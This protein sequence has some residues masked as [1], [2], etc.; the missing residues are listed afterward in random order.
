MAINS[1]IIASW[2]VVVE[3]C[4]TGKSNIKSSWLMAMERSIAVKSHITTSWPMGVGKN[5]WQPNLILHDNVMTE[6]CGGK[7]IKIMAII[8]LMES[9]MTD[10]VWQYIPSLHRNMCEMHD[11]PGLHDKIMFAI[12]AAFNV[13]HNNMGRNPKM[14]VK[15]YES[16]CLKIR[17][18]SAPKSLIPK[19]SCLLLC[20]EGSILL[21]SVS[22]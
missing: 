19:W 22:Q 21:L 2:L 6:G 15:Y 1:N 10:G 14:S 8:R 5:A 7:F 18:F 17:I 20:V 9:C 11:R 12:Y 4:M 3:K 16:L 13:A